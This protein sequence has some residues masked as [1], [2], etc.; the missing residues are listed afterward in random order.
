[1]EIDNLVDAFNHKT[2]LDWKPT[3]AFIKDFDVIIDELITFHTFINLDIYDVL[4]SCGHNLTWNYENNITLNDLNWLKNPGKTYFLDKI[5]NV[6]HINLFEY[7][8][9]LNI[10]S[11]LYHLYELQ[12]ES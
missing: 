8:S 7:S 9:I 3:H 10:Y 2:T 11:K 6:R 1:M 4:V 5:N 12:L